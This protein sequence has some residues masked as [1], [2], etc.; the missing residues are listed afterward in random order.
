MKSYKETNLST[1]ET[2]LTK[3]AKDILF[4]HAILLK[5]STS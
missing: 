5:Y 3:K 2:N 1:Y 4:A